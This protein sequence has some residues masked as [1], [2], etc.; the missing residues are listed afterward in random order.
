MN[1]NLA[2]TSLASK[3]LHTCRRQKDVTRAECNGMQDCG[4]HGG[5]ASSDIIMKSSRLESAANHQ[6]CAHYIPP[7]MPVHL[8]DNPKNFLTDFHKFLYRG[9]LLRV[10]RHAPAASHEGLHTRFC[11]HIGHNSLNSYQGETCFEEE[12]FRDEW[13]KH[14]CLRQTHFS[15]SLAV[16]DVQ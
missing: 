6:R 1:K 16:L 13:M 4:G 2:Y 10:C 11:A 15:V 8:Q 14:K 7:C 12:C 5:N 3:R 9:V